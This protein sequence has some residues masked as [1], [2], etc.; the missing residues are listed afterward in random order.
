MILEMCIT[1]YLTL[2]VQFSKNVSEALDK[3]V[4]DKN[5]LPVERN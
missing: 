2:F 1:K 3:I 4:I 5:S